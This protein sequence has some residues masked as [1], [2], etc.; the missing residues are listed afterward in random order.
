MSVLNRKILSKIGAISGI[1]A[2]LMLFVI[3][4]VLMKIPGTQTL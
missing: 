3:P 4:F 2:F 1:I